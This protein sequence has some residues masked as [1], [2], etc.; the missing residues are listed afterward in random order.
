MSFF[1]QGGIYGKGLGATFCRR[2]AAW[3]AI[4]EG[5]NQQKRA[6]PKVSAL[7]MQ[8]D[9]NLKKTDSDLDVSR[10]RDQS[11]QDSRSKR[12]DGPTG[13][14]PYAADLKEVMLNHSQHNL[15]HAATD[16]TRYESAATC[17]ALAMFSAV[18]TWTY[19]TYWGRF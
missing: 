4:R 8:E 17:S 12:T 3:T 9:P 6:N 5:R 2:D 14:L 11:V 15:T 19:Q 16:M 13:G 10:A 1:L 7:R 18:G